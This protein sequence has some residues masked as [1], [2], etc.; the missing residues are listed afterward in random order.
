MSHGVILLVKP[1]EP[2]NATQKPCIMPPVGLWQMREYLEAN[3]YSVAICDEHAGDDIE[4]YRGQYSHIGL[5]IQFSI[6]HQ[7]YKRLVK[8]CRG[9]TNHLIA[10]GVHAANVAP[11]DGVDDVVA[12]AGEAYF[13]KLFDIPMRYGNPIFEEEEMARYWAFGRPHD[14]QT[15]T[16]RWMSFT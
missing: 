4:Y 8:T 7:E 5:S 14:L 16:N 11:V 10:G 12:G 13:S 2:H 6:Q 15:V 3:G 9:W 1:P